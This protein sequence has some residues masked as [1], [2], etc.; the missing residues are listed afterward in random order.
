MFFTDFVLY[1]NCLKLDM[2]TSAAVIIWYYVCI[3]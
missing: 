2:S 1:L 3:V